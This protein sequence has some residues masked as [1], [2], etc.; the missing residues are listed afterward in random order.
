M[1]REMSD[2]AKATPVPSMLTVLDPESGEVG[3]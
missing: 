2:D 1:R 3:L